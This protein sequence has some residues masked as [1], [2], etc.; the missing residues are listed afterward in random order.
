MPPPGRSPSRCF[1]TVELWQCF[2]LQQVPACWCAFSAPTLLRVGA[3]APVRALPTRYWSLWLRALGSG[4]VWLRSVVGDVHVVVV[5]FGCI[6]LAARLVGGVTLLC[7]PSRTHSSPPPPLLLHVALALLSGAM[8][9]LMQPH[10]GSV[11]KWAWV[12][13]GQR[14]RVKARVHIL[15][16]DSKEKRSST[17]CL[18]GRVPKEKWG[19]DR[20]LLLALQ[21]AKGV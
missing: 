9:T 15:N 5:D 2:A 17:T 6:L 21:A 19:S 11:P 12:G 3:A 8:M 1:V 14:A 20:V 18:E 4:R 10:L 7:S 16:L 13:V